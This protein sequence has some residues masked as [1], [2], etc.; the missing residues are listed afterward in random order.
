[1]MLSTVSSTDAYQDDFVMKMFDYAQK[2]YFVDIGSGDPFNSS[3]S[4]RLEELGWSG[5]CIDYTRYPEYKKRNCKYFAAN[6]L[7]FNYNNFFIEYEAPKIIDYLSLDIDENT[8]ELLKLIPF[9]THE[10]KI[11]TIEHDAYLRNKDYRSKQREI[12]IEKGYHLLCSDVWPDSLRKLNLPG[13]PFEDW[14]IKRKYFSDSLIEKIQSENIYGSEVIK[15]FGFSSKE[16][17]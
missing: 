14:W 1:M 12:L 17:L 3:N 5:I 10:F 11:I 8:T 4:S 13:G 15:K 6:A 7:V 2:G 9:D 16:I